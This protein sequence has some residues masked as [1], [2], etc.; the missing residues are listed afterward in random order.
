MAAEQG[1]LVLTANHVQNGTVSV[2]PQAQPVRGA[3]DTR[4][5]LPSGRVVSRARKASV[6]GANLVVDVHGARAG[7]QLC[8][9]AYS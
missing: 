3:A 5:A 9:T 7:S 4:V 8:W 1:S 6:V 2:T